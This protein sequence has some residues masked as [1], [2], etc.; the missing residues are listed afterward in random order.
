V[1]IRLIT[2]VLNGLAQQLDM[3]ATAA[4]DYADKGA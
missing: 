1:R 3:A 4:E 2:H